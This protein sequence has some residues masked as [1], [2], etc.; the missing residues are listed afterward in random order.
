MA[1]KRNEVNSGESKTGYTGKYFRYNQ[2]EE[3]SQ[4]QE[5]AKDK[6]AARSKSKKSKKKK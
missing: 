3:Q 4:E 6:D 1:H 5:H 2:P